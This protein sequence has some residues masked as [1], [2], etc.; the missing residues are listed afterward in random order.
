V[1]DFQ[2]AI[3]G[4]FWVAIRDWEIYTLDTSDYHSNITID[5]NDRVLF[6]GQ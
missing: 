1:G 6:L 3:S 4:G 5:P 2:V